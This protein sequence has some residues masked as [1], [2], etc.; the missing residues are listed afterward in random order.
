MIR[1]LVTLERFHGEPGP[2]F[3]ST[4]L[5]PY[6]IDDDPGKVQEI[7]K[8]LILEVT[9]SEH[10]VE[11]LKHDYMES[12]GCLAI[13]NYIE[14]QLGYGNSVENWISMYGRFRFMTAKVVQRPM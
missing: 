7:G 3:T 1:F 6:Y 5:L 12:D 11:K 14:H 8:A 4:V 10:T 2:E 9:L 13:K